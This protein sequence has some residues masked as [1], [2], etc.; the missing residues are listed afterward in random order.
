[1]R[2]I[3]R[4]DVRRWKRMSEPRILKRFFGLAF[5]QQSFKNPYT[6]KTYPFSFFVKP[7]G[8]AVFALTADPKPEV[9]LVRQFKQTVGKV[10]IEAPG[11]QW[12]RSEELLLA[13][14]RELLEETGCAAESLVQTSPKDGYWLA[15]RKS[16][17][18]SHTF[19]ATGCTLV[20]AQKLDR[21]E[22]AIE[23][24]AYTPAEFWDLVQNG[25]IRSFETV[26]AAHNAV[27]RGALPPP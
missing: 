14:R 17:S 9:I 24:L 15:P 21:G 12:R 16:P 4:V 22:G 25:T 8:F 27:T 7:D 13:A 10:V 11:G 5:G 6:G 3:F 1:M 2:A 20:A 23:V 26:L 19:L 18:V